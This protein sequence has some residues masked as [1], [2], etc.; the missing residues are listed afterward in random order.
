MPFLAAL[1]AAAS[2]RQ[3]RGQAITGSGL[4][5]VRLDTFAP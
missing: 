5:T 1:V 4:N 3:L 2:L